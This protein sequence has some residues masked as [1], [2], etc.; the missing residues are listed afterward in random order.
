MR[1]TMTFSFTLRFL[2]GIAFNILLSS[3][4]GN[5]IIGTL[6]ILI[7][8]NGSFGGGLLVI[9]VVVGGFLVGLGITLIIDF[10]GTFGI[11]PC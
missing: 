1:V 6:G 4:A 10:I 3:N 8:G 5:L 11:V 2:L 9:V 7:F